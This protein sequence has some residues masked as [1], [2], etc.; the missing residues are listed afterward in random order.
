MGS[1]L[2]STMI[3]AFSLLNVGFAVQ[4]RGLSV[5][6][7][8]QEAKYV[9]EVSPEGDVSDLKQAVRALLARERI[10]DL[11]TDFFLLHGGKELTIPS[12]L[13][14]D[15]GITAET[16]VTTSETMTLNVECTET[17][18]RNWESHDIVRKPF[19][20]IKPSTTVEMLKEIIM[21]SVDLDEECSRLTEVN[22]F[23]DGG[24][25]E[26]D[27]DEVLVENESVRAG[28]VLKV[29][30]DHAEYCAEEISDEDADRF[31]PSLF[32]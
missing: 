31:S 16:V 10:G 23:L 28:S 24:D 18:H 20:Q 1:V 12:Q 13:L 4:D 25:E 3:L 30:V 19:I 17:G 27:D 6:V 22:V 32:S 7:Q 26:S 21:H 2:S 8:H 14:A 5:T 9:V 29:I 15:S 11:G